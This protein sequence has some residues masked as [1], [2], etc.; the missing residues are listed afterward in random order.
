MGNRIKFAALSL[1]FAAFGT[2][3]LAQDAPNADTVLATV[4][5]Q[6]ITLGHM[7]LLREDLPE[8]F[9]QY[10]NDIL[11]PALYG[12]LVEQTLLA[13]SLTGDIPSR[14]TYGVENED[15][16]LRSGLAIQKI[17]D[18]QVSDDAIRAAYEE[19][20]LNA[21]LGTEYNASHILVETEEAATALLVELQA[22]LDFVEA[23]QEHSTGPSGPSGGSLGWFGRGAMVAP[24][25][26]AVAAMEVGAL[27]APVQTQFGWHIIKLNETRAI[28][29]PAFELVA[30]E[31]ADEIGSAILSDVI[32]TLK[33]DAE[34][35]RVVPEDFDTSVLSDLSLLEK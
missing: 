33:V 31:L 14:I 28:E 30:E 17:Y 23:A 25:D 34:I 9:K 32:D 6:E 26:E 29:A 8:Q 20:Y 15:R 27:S 13:G 16:N 21:D 19:T 3:G 1:A 35:L 4:N 7:I 11:F 2:Q 24:F 22:G 10:P 5:G 18:D 12:Q